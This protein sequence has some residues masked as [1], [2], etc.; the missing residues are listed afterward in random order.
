[1][2]IYFLDS[3]ALVKR[4]VNEIGSAWILELFDSAL[5][6]EVFVA[7]ITGVEIIAAITRRARSGS[8]SAADAAMVCNQFRRDLQIDYQ[9]IEI[10]EEI[11]QSGM[12]L[13]EVLGLRGYDAVQLAAGCAIN[14]LCLASSLSPIVFV[15][16]DN[17][18][19]LAATSEGLLVENPNNYPS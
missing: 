17:E 15:S 7:A 6:N 5:G 11:I 2:P 19:N 16:A 9:V 8:I 14:R 13:A 18:L 1:M 3:S 12:M 10:T 4:Y